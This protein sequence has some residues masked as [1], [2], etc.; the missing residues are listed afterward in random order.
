VSGGKR[1]RENRVGGREK[2]ETRREGK[3]RGGRRGI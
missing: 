1:K 2:R 3:G